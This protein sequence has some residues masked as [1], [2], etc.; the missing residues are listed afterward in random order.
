MIFNK[1]NRTQ[2]KIQSDL[3][4]FVSDSVFS[5]IKFTRKEK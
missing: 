4:T 5:F 3:D 1:R 2:N